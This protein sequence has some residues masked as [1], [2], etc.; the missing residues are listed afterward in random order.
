MK[1]IVAS[2]ENSFNELF[3]LESIIKL[4]KESCLDKEFTS[5]YYE[6][7]GEHK[8]ILSAERNNYINMLTLALDK[9]SNLKQIIL[10]AEKEAYELEQNSN[11]SGR[12]ITA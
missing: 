7:S 3:T 10:T 9:I 1:K 12:K 2:I 8:N 6:L 4:T 11:Y 5:I